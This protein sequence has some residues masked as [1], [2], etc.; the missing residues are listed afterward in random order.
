MTIKIELRAALEALQVKKPLRLPLSTTPC[1][2]A[3]PP[4]SKS[5]TSLVQT[6]V[7][8][9]T[10]V[11]KQTVAEIVT[12]VAKQTSVEFDTLDVNPTT[13]ENITQVPSPTSDSNPTP[14]GFNTQVENH[15]PVALPTPV[16][17]DTLVVNSTLVSK[18]T[19]VGNPTQ[20]NQ[21][22]SKLPIDAQLS[23]R[24]ACEQ[25]S[26]VLFE[27]RAIDSLEKGFTRLPNC[28]LMRLANGDFTR[29]EIKVA[30]LISRFT[31]SYQRKLA[32]LSKAVL[33]RRTGLRG[34]AI[35]EA[36]SGLT[37][38]GLV[39][40]IQGDQNKPNML[41]LII[42]ASWEDP[43]VPEKR[44]QVQIATPVGTATS[45]AKVTP[46]GV[47]KPTLAPV[48]NPTLFKDI[49][50][51]LKKNSLSELP[52]SIRKYFA[53]L[54]PQKK[55]ESEWKEFETLLKDYSIQQISDSLE[56]LEIKGT[57]GEGE[58]FR[59]CHS[60][61]AYLSK[62]ISQILNQAAQ[63]RE[64]KRGSE[65]RQRREAEALMLRQERDFQEEQLGAQRNAEFLDAFPEPDEQKKAI[66]EFLLDLPG[67]NPDGPVARQLAIGN[68]WS[69]KHGK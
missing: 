52:E 44:T 45:V 2:T 37:S 59:P 8:M 34:P 1:F 6:L 53:E 31:I 47:E 54:K 50:I 5:P 51:D 3:P 10:Q 21:E 35:L 9:P 66:L 56:L 41:G 32:P 29:N 65:D 68:W 23:P 62:A 39:E 33:E 27:S 58:S 11:G 22:K 20:V 19:L 55:R 16:V 40:K 24:R 18:E 28:I 42:P 38:K 46:A 15:T 69:L 61:M 63:L 17:L 13:V 4:V 14:V 12:G 57:G 60:P 67:I 64:Q 43:S 49:K 26:S 25:D 30:L 36:L 7:E 48:G